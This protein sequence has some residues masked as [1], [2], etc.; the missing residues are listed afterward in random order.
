MNI[1]RVALFAPLFFLAGISAARAD[2]PPPDD[3]VEKCTVA[4]KEQTG[5]TCEACQNSYES[6]QGNDPCKT[7]YTGTNFTHVCKS[8]GASAWTEVWCDGP[9]RP[10]SDDSDSG[11]S[12]AN[13]SLGKSAQLTVP[14]GLGL[15]ALAFAR[16]RRQRERRSPRAKS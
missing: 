6:F 1:I 2:M 11:C 13:S 9:P 10:E 4:L 15:I 5:T 8:W 12:Y 16:K 7:K 14:I 3:Y